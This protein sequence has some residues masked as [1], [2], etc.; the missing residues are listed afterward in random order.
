MDTN[1][2]EISFNEMEQVNGGNFLDVIKEKAKDAWKEIKKMAEEV[3][4]K[5]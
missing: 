2:K 4:T 3:Q 5:F 1:M